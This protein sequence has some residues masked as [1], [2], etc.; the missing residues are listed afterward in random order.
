[1]PEKSNK[2]DPEEQLAFEQ[3]YR[4]KRLELAKQKGVAAAEA[5]ANKKPFYKKVLGALD[6]VGK[7]IASTDFQLP[8]V[9]PLTGV[10]LREPSRKRR[11]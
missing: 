2:K 9:D 7:D 8:E 11:T 1:M 6:A 4:E 10:R 3:A 5:E